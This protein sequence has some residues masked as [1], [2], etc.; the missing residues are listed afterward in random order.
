MSLLGGGCVY[1]GVVCLCLHERERDRG[2]GRYSEGERSVEI[3]E[4][5]IDKLEG[6]R[7]RG[8]RG[9]G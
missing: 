7:W 9:C 2:T 8:H 6:W 3:G 5:K 1:V 4:S